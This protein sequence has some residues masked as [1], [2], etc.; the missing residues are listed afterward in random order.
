MMLDDPARFP[1]VGAFYPALDLRYSCNGNRLADC[2]PDCYDPWKTTSRTG[3]WSPAARRPICSPKGSSFFRYSTPIA[4]A[5]RSCRKTSRCG[6]ACASASTPKL[7]WIDAGIV[8]AAK[9]AF[10]P[11][12]PEERGPLFE[13][14]IAMLLSAYRDLRGAF[15]ELFY[16]APVESR[17]I[18]VDF[19]LRSGRE[20]IAIEVKAGTRFSN[21]MADGLR[22]IAGLSSPDT[23]IVSAHLLMDY[24]LHNAKQHGAEIACGTTVTAIAATNKAKAV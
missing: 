18:E 7:Y 3:R 16:W 22:A 11:P 5:D 12:S 1:N 24:F 20:Y 14:W 10:G 23:G 21:D 2:R 17:K 13:G 15:D 8:R 6:S 19:L 4:G 9:G